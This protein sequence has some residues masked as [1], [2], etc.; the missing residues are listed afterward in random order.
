L[1]NW[2]WG[3]DWG[4]V[5]A[6]LLIGSCPI[7]PGDIDHICESARVTA[8]LSLQTDRC[9]ANLGIDYAAN[10][11]RAQRLGLV[12][13]SAPMRDFDLPDQRLRLPSAVRALGG[14]LSA[15]H[16]VFVHCTAGVNRAPL[17][18][19]GYMTFVE[20][21]AP[22]AAFEVIRRS[23]PQAAPYWEAYHGCRADLVDR[24]RELV[25]LHAYLISERNTGRDPLEDWLEAEREVICEALGRPDSQAWQRLD[26]AA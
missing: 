26:A 1:D 10:C 6:D 18:V 25:Q 2:T 21:L 8:L 13:E 22:E 24:L 17:T 12:L 20:G 19:L 3:L 15:G 11:R 9:R 16:R 4:E 7:V 14:L 5:R 23:R